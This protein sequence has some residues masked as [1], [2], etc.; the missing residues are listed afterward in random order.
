MITKKISS[1]V[2]AVTMRSPNSNSTTLTLFV[3]CRGPMTLTMIH[4]ELQF[5]SASNLLL[6]GTYVWCYTISNHDWESCVSF[7]DMGAD[8]YFHCRSSWRKL[9]LRSTE[10][11]DWSGGN[12]LIRH[13]PCYSSQSLF[14]ANGF[15]HTSFRSFTLPS[16]FKK[17]K[18]LAYYRAQYE[19]YHQAPQTTFLSNYRSCIDG[20]TGIIASCT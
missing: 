9:R 4:R 12:C 16:S 2:W 15:G 13:T 17:Y 10:T 8:W 18:S 3:S 19:I 14:Y 1:L 20:P 7:P 11:M 5:D 6:P